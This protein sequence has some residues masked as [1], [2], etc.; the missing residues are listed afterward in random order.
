MHPLFESCPPILPKEN[1]PKGHLAENLIC[2][3][4]KQISEINGLAKYGCEVC[5][6][7]SEINGL[8]NIWMWCL[9]TN[10]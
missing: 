10:D 6:Q 4:C 3:L 1:L 2:S 7:I 8:S 9:S 5:Q